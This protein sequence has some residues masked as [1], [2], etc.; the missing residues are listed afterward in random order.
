MYLAYIPDFFAMV[1]S[2]KEAIGIP[3]S[4]LIFTWEHK[5]AIFDFLDGDVCV[6]HPSFYIN[7]LYYIMI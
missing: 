3:A 6:V 7:Y 5:I 2:I 4:I 1:E